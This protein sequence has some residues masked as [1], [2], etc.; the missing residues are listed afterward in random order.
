MRISH[1]YYST[2][3]SVLSRCYDNKVLNVLIMPKRFLQSTPVIKKLKVTC[4]LQQ[5]QT[6]QELKINESDKMVNNLEIDSSNGNCTRD[7]KVEYLNPPVK[8]ESDK[9]LY[10][11]VALFL[12]F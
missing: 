9:K 11:L 3:L 5:K 1:V 7:I 4:D 10:R 2:V 6:N 8:S 12:L